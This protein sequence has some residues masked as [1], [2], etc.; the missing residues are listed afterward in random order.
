MTMSEGR[1]RMNDPE[2]SWKQ[3]W[4]FRT[5]LDMFIEY[6]FRPIKLTPDQHVMARMIGNGEDIKGV[7]HR[8]FGKTWLVALCVLAL[9]VLYPGSAVLVISATAKQATLLVRK[10]QDLANINPNIA[11]EFAV[12]GKSLELHA[13]DSTSSC[14]VKNDSTAISSAIDSARGGRYKITV[15]D[16]AL[17]VDPAKVE[18]IVEPTKNATRDFAS[19]HG[20]KDY[21][22]K[23]ITITSACE[24]GNPFYDKLVQNLAF[25]ADNKHKA[26][27]WAL[28][29]Q[30]AVD[31][32]L[33][34]QEFF[35]KE[36]ERMPELLFQMEY[37]SRFP[38]ANKDAALPYDLVEQCRTL[39]HVEI[40]Q[41]TNSKS[42]YVFSLD[43]ATSSA[44]DSDNSIICVIKFTER[45]D[46]SFAK[47]LVYMKSYNGKGLDYL[48]NEIRK[49]Y[50][51]FPNV[52]KIVYDARGLGDSLDKF[53]S[54]DYVDE[55]TGREF[56]PFVVDDQPNMNPIAIPILHPF[57]A[58]QSLNQRIYT[59][60]RVSLEKRQVEIPVHSQVIRRQQAE[61]ENP[62]KRMKDNEM[63]VYL[64]C[65]ALQVEMGNIVARVGAS[66]NVLYDVPRAHLHKDRYSSF[67]MGLDYICEL[68][69][70]QMKRRNSQHKLIGF[71]IR[72]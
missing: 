55:T 5:H 68:E 66:G 44:K 64:E 1:F 25:F 2:T 23:S 9:M 11:N 32:G 15:V 63:A 14:R 50:V 16:E 7:N 47:K 37:E 54:T 13:R 20:I 33:T 22:S 49:L 51:L 10:L 18:A 42:R 3:L 43:I 69:K 6:A 41:P 57:R 35:D 34:P 59:N 52:E 27:A 38:G 46:G 39:P 36:R 17:Q 8:G 24:Q 19:Y 62:A 70:D 60:M 61:I 56:P 72:L 21:A 26:Y 65:D 29:Y 67:A 58:V 45:A 48:A 71:T 31:W 53:F 28:S 4:Y 12:R 30:T 40:K